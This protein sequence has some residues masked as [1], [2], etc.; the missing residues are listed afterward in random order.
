M[1][2]DH[3]LNQVVRG[4]ILQKAQIGESLSQILAS[5]CLYP[6]MGDGALALCPAYLFIGSLIKPRGPLILILLISMLS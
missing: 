4:L 6:G 5:P 3:W 1:T 2:P